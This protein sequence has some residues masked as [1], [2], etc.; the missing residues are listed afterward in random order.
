MQNLFRAA[1]FIFVKIQKQPRYLQ[2]DKWLA[3]MFNEKTQKI[4]FYL[5]HV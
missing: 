3:I 5:K 4:Y 1:L 2:C